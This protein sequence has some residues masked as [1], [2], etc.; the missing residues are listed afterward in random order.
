MFDAIIKACPAKCMHA[1]NKKKTVKK[2]LSMNVGM[3]RCVK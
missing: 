1:E 3:E 2:K